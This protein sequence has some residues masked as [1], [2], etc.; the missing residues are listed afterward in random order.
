MVARPP[1]PN[2]LTRDLRKEIDSSPKA[3]QGLSAPRHLRPQPPQTRRAIPNR[4][5]AAETASKGKA[6]N[7]ERHDYDSVAR[8]FRRQY[9]GARGAKIWERIYPQVITGYASVGEVEQGDARQ[10]LGERVRWRQRAGARG[11][12]SRKLVAV[13]TRPGALTS[14]SDFDNVPGHEVHRHVRGFGV[15][16]AGGLL[17]RPGT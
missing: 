8:K 7:P 9:P 16:G 6:W 4:P 1:A 13:R 2:Q 10:Q 12:R 14:P 5:T 11:S 17:G 15:A 3:D